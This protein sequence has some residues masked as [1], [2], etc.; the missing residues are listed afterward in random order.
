MTAGKRKHFGKQVYMGSNTLSLG[1]CRECGAHNPTIPGEG[2]AE[3]CA[4]CRTPLYRDDR[5]VKPGQF[6]RKK[7]R[8]EGFSPRSGG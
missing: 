2:L 8:T 3:T 1:K 6:E 5:T 7:G 4:S